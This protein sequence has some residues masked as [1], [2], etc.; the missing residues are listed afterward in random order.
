MRLLM[1]SMIS[2]TI[3][4]YASEHDY[5]NIG[6]LTFA[7]YKDAQSNDHLVINGLDLKNPIDTIK[8]IAIKIVTHRGGLGG[9]RSVMH[10]GEPKIYPHV[11]GLWPVSIPYSE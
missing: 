1:I 2:W 5:N 11:N 7:T 6:L 10:F 4:Q 9:P 8:P 3:A